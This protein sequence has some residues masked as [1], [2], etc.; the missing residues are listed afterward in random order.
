ME[1]YLWRLDMIAPEDSYDAVAAFLT[2]ASPAGWEEISQEGGATLFRAH[3]E[4]RE[5]LDKLAKEFVALVPGA[6]A[7]PEK[8]ERLDWTEA[9]K[10]YFTPVECGSRFVVAPPWL[11]GASFPGLNKI[12]IEP[13]SAFGTG[14]HA[15]TRLC[16]TA[17]AKILIEEP[18]PGDFLDFGCGSGVLGLAA[19]GAGLR[20]MG[21]DI[22]PLAIENANK[23]R[24]LNAAANLELF[25][26]GLERVGPR[27][28]GLIMANILP[29]PLIEFAPALLEAL[30]AGGK[31]VLSGVLATRAEE[32]KSAYRSLGEPEIL[33]EGEWRALVWR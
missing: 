16:L 28:F 19:C 5:F 14:H 25:W 10:E 23:N 15:T 30:A 18:N 8:A 3:A 11:A 22:D 17:L 20:G 21:V 27:K 24:D 32:V 1:K 4:N 12:L 33:A 26:G 13:A 29:E 2:F 31:L 7:E 9:W 6:K